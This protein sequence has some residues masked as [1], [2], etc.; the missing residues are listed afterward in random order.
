MKTQRI[1][2]HDVSSTELSD[3]TAQI[4]I[5]ERAGAGILL[6]PR[7][8]DQVWKLDPLSSAVSVAGNS[9][10]RRAKH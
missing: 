5:G 1:W 9:M 8:F 3:A 2:L 6:P 10:V 7:R 4:S